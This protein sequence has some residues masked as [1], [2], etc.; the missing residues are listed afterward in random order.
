MSRV[1]LLDT[2]T[3]INAVIVNRPGSSFKLSGDAQGEIYLLGSQTGDKYLLKSCDLPVGEKITLD[4]SGSI[5]VTMIF[6]PV[7]AEDLTADLI[8]DEKGT[9]SVIG[10]TVQMSDSVRNR[11]LCHLK[12]ELFDMPNTKALLL[13]PWLKTDISLKD[14]TVAKVIPVT[15]G[16]FECEIPCGE[17]GDL[18]TLIPWDQYISYS[19]SSASFFTER[20]D[21]Q[22]S[23]TDDLLPTIKGGEYNTILSLAN[24]P[25]IRVEAEYSPQIIKLEEDGLAGSQKTM[26]LLRKIEEAKDEKT[27]NKY[28]NELY[29]LPKEELYSPEY[30]SLINRYEQ[31]SK[32]VQ[33]SLFVEIEQNVSM[34]YLPILFYFLNVADQKERFGGQIDHK[35]NDIAKLYYEQFQEKKDNPLVVRLAEYLNSRLS[36]VGNQ[37][38]DFDA[39]DRDG[40]MF[41]F[42]EMIKGSKLVL[43]DMWA[44]W[45]GGCRESAIKNKPI[46]DQY[47]DKGFC[48]VSIARE[49][50]DLDDLNIAVEKDGYTWPVLV[51]LD[52]RINLWRTYNAGDSGGLLVLID[53][54][55]G[56]IIARGP[57]TE[58]IESVVKEYCGSDHSLI[59]VK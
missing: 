17:H 55:T 29:S 16:K 24:E 36:S 40:K 58:K 23:W 49:Y 7:G 25:S 47:K 28:E 27:R 53:P 56:K 32:E 42:S 26:D 15:E 52:D 21:V 45:C 8:A 43:L 37:F 10:L 22:I 13:W 41:R 39:P 59:I 12:G 11:P 9:Y 38:I 50:K 5:L 18:Y 4:K 19:F 48:V 35:L 46:Y 6:E 14:P 31:R 34:G 30:F 1:E 2:A 20:G 57:S 44:S 51:E 3:V 54:A 33:D